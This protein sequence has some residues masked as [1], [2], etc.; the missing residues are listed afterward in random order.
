M[1]QLLV[2][3][4]DELHAQLEQFPN[5]SETVRLAIISYLAVGPSSGHKTCVTKEEVLDLIKS[6]IST[7]GYSTE[8]V[9]LPTDIPG[10]TTGAAFVPKPP[11][12]DKGYPCCAGRTPCKHWLWDDTGAEWKNS[13]TGKT[14]EVL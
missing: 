13:I 4:D 7:H 9:K 3:I 2:K 1:K 8:P 6:T 12:P 11:D 14:R 10:L 5:K